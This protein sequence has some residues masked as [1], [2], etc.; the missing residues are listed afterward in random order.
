MIYNAWAAVVSVFIAFFLFLYFR[1]FFDHRFVNF[2]RHHYQA[3]AR[4][5]LSLSLMVGLIDWSLHVGLFNG[6]ALKETVE[7]AGEEDELQNLLD[8]GSALGYM[9]RFTLSARSQW[10]KYMNAMTDQSMRDASRDLHVEYEAMFTPLT[11]QTYCDQRVP[12]PPTLRTIDNAM[13]Y[14]MYHAIILAGS[15]F[16]KWYANS[17]TV[18]FGPAS[19]FCELYGTFPALTDALGASRAN[20]MGRSSDEG[21]EAKALIGALQWLMP[22]AY[23]IMALLPLPMCVVMLLREMMHDCLL[24]EEIGEEFREE[25]S[26]PLRR[27]VA[28]KPFHQERSTRRASTR[29][30]GRSSRCSCCYTRR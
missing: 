12:L 9:Q 22:I 4:S 3:V 15:E 11:N 30:S 17:E 24:L 29:S 1:A 25:A 28:N 27:N 14:A 5:D 2:E 13:A 16:P 6:S 10:D 20:E 7:R 18:P 8:Q 19:R 23:S 21:G 26:A